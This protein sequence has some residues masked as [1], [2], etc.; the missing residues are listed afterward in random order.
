[1]CV[2]IVVAVVAVVVSFD[3]LQSHTRGTQREPHTRARPTNYITF[4]E[5]NFA[6]RAAAAAAAVAQ[7][8]GSAISPQPHRVCARRAPGDE[9]RPRIMCAKHAIHAR[10]CGRIERARS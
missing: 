1:M 8:N 5:N 3:D 4:A 7:H 9:C 6:A 10:A 2:C